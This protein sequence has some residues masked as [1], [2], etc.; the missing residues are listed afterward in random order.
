MSFLKND[1][2]KSSRYLIVTLLACRLIRNVCGVTCLS[3]IAKAFLA[4]YDVGYERFNLNLNL[5]SGCFFCF[6]FFLYT[7]GV[8]GWFIFHFRSI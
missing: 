5:I 4:H 6:C 7:R 2:F 3:T 8:G 1:L